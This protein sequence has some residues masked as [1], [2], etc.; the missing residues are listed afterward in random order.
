MGAEIP[1]S[2]AKPITRAELEQIECTI[3]VKVALLMAWK[4]ASRLDEIAKLTPESV[5]H[6]SPD[7]VI[8]WFGRHTKTSRSRPFMAQLFQV[9]KGT[10]T[11]F[12]HNNLAE[13]FQSWP[14]TSAMAQALPKPYTMHSIKHGAGQVLLKAWVEGKVDFELTQTVMKHAGAKTVSE[15]TIRYMSQN[16]ADLARAIGTGEATQYL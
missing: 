3:P 1:N 12:I 2:Q 4:T 13:A 5:V 7:E 16:K 11:E 9:I 15:T 6:S 14:T 8:L 10:H